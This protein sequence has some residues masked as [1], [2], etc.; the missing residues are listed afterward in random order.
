MADVLCVNGFGAI[1]EKVRDGADFIVVL[2]TAAEA[3]AVLAAYTGLDTLLAAAG[4]TEAVFDNYAREVVANASITLTDDDTGASVD[5][6]DITWADAGGTTDETTAKLLVCEDGA[7][8]AARVPLMAFDF[9]ATTDGN[10][11]TARVHANG[12]WST[13]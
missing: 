2:L 7:S 5:I 11:L 4:N 12:L 3:D 9:V 13:S 6:A 10:D 1:A 8:D